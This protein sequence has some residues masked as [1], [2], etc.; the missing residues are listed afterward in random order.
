MAEG[1]KR[2]VRELH[3]SYHIFF[4][5]EDED[6]DETMTFGATTVLESRR[7]R[8]RGVGEES[9]DRSSNEMFR[10]EYREGLIV[11]CDLCY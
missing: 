9:L 11:P 5:D 6:A 8:S 10:D 7:R 2:L 4:K 1:Y 3:S